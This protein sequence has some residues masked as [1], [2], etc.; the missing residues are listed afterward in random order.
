LYCLRICTTS[1]QHLLAFIVSGKKSGINL[2][3]LSL[4]VP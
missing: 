2:I 1:L 4:Y 3:G